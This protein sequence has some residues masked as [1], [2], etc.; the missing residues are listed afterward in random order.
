M[1]QVRLVAQPGTKTPEEW[2]AFQTLTVLGA[3]NLERAKAIVEPNPKNLAQAYGVYKQ[4]NNR[5]AIANILRPIV[6][7]IL[8]K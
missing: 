2:A 1:Q 3:F 6:S 7:R 5:G 8:P 4:G